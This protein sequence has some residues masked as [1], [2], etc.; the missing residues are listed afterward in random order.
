MNNSLK[1]YPKSVI[2]LYKPFPPL[3]E[4]KEGFGF[5]GTVLLD[6]DEN[7]I[8]CHLCGEWFSSLIPHLKPAHNMEVEE[9]KEEF[10]LNVTTPLCSP[11]VSRKLRKHMKRLRK[12]YPKRMTLTQKRIRNGIKASLNSPK[13]KNVSILY[14]NRSGRCPLQIKEAL[15]RFAYKYGDDFSVRQLKKNNYRLWKA[16]EYWYGSFNLAKK[17]AGITINK[18]KE[19][20]DDNYLLEVLATFRK[21]KKRWPTIYKLDK[22]GTLP[23]STT[24]IRH[25]GTYSEAKRRAND[26]C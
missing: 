23:A 1:N 13:R 25:F 8:Q 4:V 15:R 12:R 5:L 10:G 17:A 24:Y 7:K 22:D 16:V 18:K 11:E 3:M 9:Y 26:L 14:R 19:K 2:A 20:I 6:T 21:E